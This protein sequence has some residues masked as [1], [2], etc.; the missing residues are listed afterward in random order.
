MEASAK[1]DNVKDYYGKV[2]TDTSGLKTS[3]CSSRSAPHPTVCRIIRTQVPAAVNDRFFGCGNP[4]P[5]GIGGMDVLD[6]GSG[7]GRDSYV[8]A[9]LVG[10]AGSVTGIDMTDEQLEVAR[11]NVAPFAETLGFQPKIRF[12]TGYIEDLAA[13]GVT[14]ASVDLCISNC[15]VNLSHD[16]HAVLAGVFAALRPGGELHFADMYCDRRLSASLSDNKVL[17]GE[18]LA[19][20]LYVPD[21]ER[22]AYDI[23]FA[24]PRVLDA[25]RIDIFA[26]E[27]RALVGAAQYFSVTYRLFKPDNATPQAAA[28]DRVAVYKGSVDGCEREYALDISN[29]FAAGKPTR[30]SVETAAVLESSWLSKH[31]TL[32]PCSAAAAEPGST[33]TTTL[34]MLQAL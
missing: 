12:L 32:E 29:T 9:A 33:S 19:G 15:V 7:S 5:L 18:G 25:K 4:I 1:R 26:P 28:V 11:A 17:H 13:A 27:L 34:S 10:P 16:K 6:L 22:M 24:A 3:A 20:A 14:C 8:A 2:L 23:G 31:F 30:V 21:F